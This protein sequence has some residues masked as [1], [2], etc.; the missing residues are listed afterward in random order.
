[1]INFKKNIRKTPTSHTR[2]ITRIG[3]DLN[4]WIMVVRKQSLPV[5]QNNVTRTV[6]IAM[7][8]FMELDAPRKSL[9]RCQ[10]MKKKQFIL[11][12]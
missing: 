2:S 3:S 4:A 10:G 12:V 8:S 11:V 9:V 6:C 1:M 7:G 5:D